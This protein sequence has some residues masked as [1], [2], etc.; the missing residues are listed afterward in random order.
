MVICAT[1]GGVITVLKS[2]K[3]QT[4][5]KMAG[6]ESMVKGPKNQCL[7]ENTKLSVR[8]GCREDRNRRSK[9][10]IQEEKK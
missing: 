1:D 6:E 2:I 10:S 4:I 3:R 8:D 5:P 9:V 7:R